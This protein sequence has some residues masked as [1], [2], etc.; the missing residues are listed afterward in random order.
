MSIT[1]LQ[2]RPIVIGTPIEIE[3]AVDKIRQ[4]LASELSWVTHPYFIAQR[5]YRLKD[6]GV[7]YYPETYAPTKAGDRGYQRLT[8]DNDFKGMFFFMVGNGTP[9]EYAPS[10]ENFM[11]YPVGIIFSANL[12]LIDKAKLNNGL[13]TQELVKDARRALTTKQIALGLD[14]EILNETR[15]IRE[16]YLEFSLKALETYNRGSQQCFRINLNITIQEDCD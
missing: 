12:D 4:M 15:D 13:F 14:Y 3:S 10:Q 16:V 1:S 7:F 6:E 11:I 2:S 9:V 8:P 5:F